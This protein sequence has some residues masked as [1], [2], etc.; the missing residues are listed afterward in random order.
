MSESYTH[1]GFGW[2]L[3]NIGDMDGDGHD[4]LAVSNLFDTIRLS[5]FLSS[6]RQAP[7]SR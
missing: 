1:G 2:S 5:I 6:G 3:A 7:E 4:D